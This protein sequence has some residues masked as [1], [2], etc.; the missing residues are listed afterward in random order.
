MQVA[1]PLANTL[2]TASGKSLYQP[3]WYWVHCD[4]AVTSFG[5]LAVA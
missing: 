2:L 1:D 5:V 4:G 3:C